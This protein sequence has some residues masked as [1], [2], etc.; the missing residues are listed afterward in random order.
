MQN[1]SLKTQ[2]GFEYILSKTDDGRVL[3]NF[4]LDEFRYFGDYLEEREV[5][6]L[7]KFLTEK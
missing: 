2:H 7:I 6:K 5:K 3:V 1:T 4:S